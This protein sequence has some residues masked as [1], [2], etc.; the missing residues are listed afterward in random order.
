[1]TDQPKVV[2]QQSAELDAEAVVAY[3][4]AH[5]TFFAEHDELLIEQHIPHQRGDSVSLVER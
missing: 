5:P 2:P 4:R 1:M 3:L